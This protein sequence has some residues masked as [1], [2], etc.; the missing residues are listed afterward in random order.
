VKWQTW[1]RSVSCVLCVGLFVLSELYSALATAL[2]HSAPAWERM[3]AWLLFLLPLELIAA[4]VLLFNR[5]RARL[6]Y[7]LVVL[8]LLL[9]AGFFAVEMWVYHDAPARGTDWLILG[10]WVFFFS[11]VW[12]SA[13]F[14]VVGSGSSRS[15]SDAADDLK[16]TSFRS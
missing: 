1:A 12:L 10:I 11:G 16:E 9:Y 15:S 13:R 7:R 6:G 3:L 14:M 8:N 5:E 2:D 4:M